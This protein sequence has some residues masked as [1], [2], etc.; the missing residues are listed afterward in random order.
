MEDQKFA[1]QVYPHRPIRDVIPGQVIF[2]P[3]IL[4]LTKDQAG[5]CIG[6][7]PIYRLMNGQA[8]IKLT[9]E[10]INKLHRATLNDVIVDNRTDNTETHVEE[11]I[12]ETVVEE[13]PKTD[14]TEEVE[15]TKTVA[16]EPVEEVKEVVEDVIVPVEDTEEEVI[17]ADTDTEVEADES[18]VNENSNNQSNNRKK[19]NHK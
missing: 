16:E 18:P 11:Q 19:K 8:P 13:E 15:T 9:G 10:N 5:K 4:Q 14:T 12:P 2:K 7:G 6:F 17:T 3:T 1:Y